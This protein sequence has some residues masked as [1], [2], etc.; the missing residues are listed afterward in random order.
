MMEALVRSSP[1]DHSLVPCWRCNLMMMNDAQVL[2]LPR[3]GAGLR[4]QSFTHKNVP[5]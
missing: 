5:S 3:G 1:V 4:Q 2:L